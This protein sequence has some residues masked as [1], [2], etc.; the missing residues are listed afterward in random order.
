MRAGAED[1]EV[2]TGSVIFVAAEV[3]HRFHSI[4]EEL[5]VLVFFA[6]AESAA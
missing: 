6:P 2:T 5:V 4:T 3:D 1:Q